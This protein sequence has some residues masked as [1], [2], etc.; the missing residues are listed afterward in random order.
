M[1]V[2]TSRQQE[3]W[4]VKTIYF[5]YLDNPTCSEMGKVALSPEV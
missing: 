1:Y 3:N 2:V 4:R 5:V